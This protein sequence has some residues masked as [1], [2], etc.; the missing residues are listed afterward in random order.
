MLLRQNKLN[1]LEDWCA[2]NSIFLDDKIYLGNHGQSGIGVFSKS[3]HIQPQN[4][5]SRIS[6]TSVL[7]VRSCSLAGVIS[8]APY[9][10]AAQLSLSLALYVEMYSRWYG[11]LES[12]P[13]GIVDLP[14]FWSLPP[15]ANTAVT[16]TQ[17]ALTGSICLTGTEAAKIRDKELE[18]GGTA[19]VRYSG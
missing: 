14:I 10:L 7:S 15:E 1:A 19:L 16:A 12:F 4:T 5:L 18:T 6:K 8:N 3:D 9:G 2:E 17:N 13:V 11:Y